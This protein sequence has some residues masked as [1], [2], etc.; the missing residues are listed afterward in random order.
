MSTKE[1]AS[2]IKTATA[3]TNVVKKKGKGA[4]GDTATLTEVRLHF[5]NSA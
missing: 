5:L 3:V 2:A 1:V 4:K